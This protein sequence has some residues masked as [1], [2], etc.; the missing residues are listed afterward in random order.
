MLHLF[1]RD[2]FDVIISAE[3]M[4]LRTMVALAHKRTRDQELFFKEVKYLFH[5]CDYRSQFDGQEK[6]VRKQSAHFAAGLPADWVENVEVQAL[7]EEYQ[8]TLETLVPTTKLLRIGRQG[9]N[10]VS[11]S[12]ETIIIEIRAIRLSLQGRSPTQER[13]I[14]SQSGMKKIN[15]LSKNGPDIA[16]MAATATEAKMVQLDRI[17]TLNTKVMKMIGEIPNMV[18]DL[19]NILVQVK[20]E[21]SEAAELR[22]GGK[23]GNRE[24]P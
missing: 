17:A 4:T 2:N 8:R 21:E 12:I 3:A 11:D 16:T 18:K 23:K 10:E 14:A 13:K 1:E 24:D 15:G 7:V 19:E 22:G 9:L 6:S 20:K 5:Y